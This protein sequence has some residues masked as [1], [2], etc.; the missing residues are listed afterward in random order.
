MTKSLLIISILRFLLDITPWKN[1]E[2]GSSS[3]IHNNLSFSHCIL[4]L[5]LNREH[6][7]NEIERNSS[8]SHSSSLYSSLVMK[9]L[10]LKEYFSKRVFL[11]FLQKRNWGFEIWQEKFFS[12]S[13][14]FLCTLHES[15]SIF[16]LSSSLCFEWCHY[17]L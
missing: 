3:L 12:Q 13:S 8:I 11:V 5:I 17:F 7:F 4:Q 16:W 1:F 14:S 9:H 6:T 2:L 10:S 15:R